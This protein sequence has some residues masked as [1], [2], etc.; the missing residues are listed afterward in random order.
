MVSFNLKDGKEYEIPDKIIVQITK[1]D[2]SLSDGERIVKQDLKTGLNEALELGIISVKKEYQKLGVT[3]FII[4]KLFDR[5][6]QN[7]NIEYA[8][9]GVQLETNTGAISSLDMFERELIRKKTCY[10]KSLKE[11]DA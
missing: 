2:T 8:V 5:V 7:P 6:C 3:A 4:K 1:T 10:I 9:T 11:K